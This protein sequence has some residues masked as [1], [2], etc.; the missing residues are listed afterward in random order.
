MIILYISFLD[1]FIII[2]DYDF[3]FLLISL[4]ALFVRIYFYVGARLT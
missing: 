3:S 2:E 1:M 4:S